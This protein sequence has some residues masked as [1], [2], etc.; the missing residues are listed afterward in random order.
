MEIDLLGTA[1][2]EL[3][4][5][6]LCSGFP[7]L[8]RGH[9]PMTGEFPLSCERADDEIFPK[10]QNQKTHGDDGKNGLGVE[11]DVHDSALQKLCVRFVSVL[12]P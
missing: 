2:Y 7:I 6:D 11:I 3:I 5:A 9:I 10:D 8:V 4:P 12:L 1:D